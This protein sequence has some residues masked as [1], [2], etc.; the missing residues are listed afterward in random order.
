MR[1]CR[2]CGEDFPMRERAYFVGEGLLSKKRASKRGNKVSWYW[3]A[4]LK[5]WFKAACTRALQSFGVTLAQTD[6]TPCAPQ[7]NAG[8]A[9]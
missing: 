9:E 1:G 4:V 7:A 3:R 6:M 2:T 5:S 8:R